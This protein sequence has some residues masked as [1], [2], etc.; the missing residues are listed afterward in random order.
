M[1]V[2]V[3]LALLVPTIV[4]AKYQSPRLEHEPITIAIVFSSQH[5]MVFDRDPLGVYP[6]EVHEALRIALDAV[7]DEYAG[8]VSARLAIDDA[9]PVLAPGSEAILIGY[10]VGAHVI[11]R[12]DFDQLRGASLGDAMR[13]RDRFGTD[14]VIGLEIA[15]A[16]LARSPNHRRALI[17]IG[18]GGDTDL[19]TAP[20]RL[21]S[22]KSRAY[23]LRTR[24]YGL[25]YRRATSPDVD[26]FPLLT[27]DTESAEPLA[28]KLSALIWRIVGEQPL[29]ERA[30]SR[31]PAEPRRI[32]W[33]WLGVGMFVIAIT[34]GLRLARPRPAA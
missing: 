6:P 19:H 8:R 11:A 34:A 7:H 31:R 4:R 28:T 23:E 24:V 1:R 22:F 3:L 2:L 29:I 20:S 16:E 17:I 12:M 26:L 33:F 32:P 10:D 9:M 13:Y 18:D 30:V 14:L 15:L 27:D 21:A 25:R 5:P